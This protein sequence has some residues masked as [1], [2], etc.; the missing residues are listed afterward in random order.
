MAVAWAKRGCLTLL[1]TLLVLALLLAAAGAWW[2]HSYRAF[3]EQ[4]L[5]ATQPSVEV[6]RGASL[7]GV[8]RNLR[9]AGVTQ[10]SDL[11]WQLLARE[12]GV[13]GKLRFGE[14]ALQPALSPRELLL[15][16]RKGQVIQYRF[17]IVEGWNVRQLRS[18]LNAATPLVHTT[19]DLSDSE[20]MAKL[21]QPG[22][23]P[24]GRF[25]PET[26]LYQRG[27]T[28]LQLLRRAHAA[29]DK[30]LAAAWDA[31]AKDLSL[32]S[33]EQALILAS[34]VEKETG[35]AAERP[36]IAGVFVRRLQLGMK[37]QTDPTVIYGIGSAYDGN[38]RKRDLET[39]TPYN[40]YTRTGLTPT[41]IAMPGREALRAATNPAPGDSLYFVAIGDG[42]GAHA[43]SSSYAEHNAAVARYLQRLRQARNGAAVTP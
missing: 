39:D 38:I 19:T 10:G 15:R 32:Q 21:G 13:A 23:H 42:S 37:L 16:M 3:A 27:D 17:T 30:A 36:Q 43:F 6:A 12:L 25:L 22:Q 8:L 31:R 2:W 7:N 24:E 28:D 35:L 40:T 5:R 20:L 4:P 33:P 18:A 34:I 14:Y 11:Q 26:Y 41:P 29:M 1:G 9:A